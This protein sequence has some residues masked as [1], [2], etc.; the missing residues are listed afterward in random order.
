MNLI[1]SYGAVDDE[2]LHKRG[3][4]FLGAAQ[5][6]DNMEV[7]IFEYITLEDYKSIDNQNVRKLIDE[8]VHDLHS[9]SKTK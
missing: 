7:H 2:I 3:L 5:D 8:T 6:K 1:L 4:K 9:H